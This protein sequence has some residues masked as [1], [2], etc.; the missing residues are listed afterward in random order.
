MVHIWDNVLTDRQTDRQIDKKT[1]YFCVTRMNRAY[2]ASG[3]QEE[4]ALFLMQ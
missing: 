4:D 2:F 1:I 3:F